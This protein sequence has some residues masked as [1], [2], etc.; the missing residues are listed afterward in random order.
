[1][2][3]LAPL[4]ADVA[5]ALGA[6]NPGAQGQAGRTQDQPAHSAGPSRNHLEPIE[7]GLSDLARATPWNPH[8]STLLALCDALGIALSTMTVDVF[9]PPTNVEIDVSDLT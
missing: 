9:G 7:R 8:L 3:A 6:Q 1:M 5:A 4:D 2:P